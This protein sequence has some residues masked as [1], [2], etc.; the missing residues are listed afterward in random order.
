MPI[1]GTRTAHAG[2]QQ[3]DGG[4]HSMTPLAIVAGPQR[5]LQ[6]L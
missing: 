2:H 5:G 3:D 1:L 6:T 4:D